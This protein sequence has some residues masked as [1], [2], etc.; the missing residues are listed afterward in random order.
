MGIGVRILLRASF[1]AKRVFSWNSRYPVTGVIL[2][3]KQK[4][5]LRQT[6]LKSLA[7]HRIKGFCNAFCTP[8]FATGVDKESA[9]LPWI[10]SDKLRMELFFEGKGYKRILFHLIFPEL[11][12]S[13]VVFDGV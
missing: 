4:T 3:I 2:Y 1:S 12:W 10:V 11:W 13:L 5:K 9:C 8:I 7:F 6:P